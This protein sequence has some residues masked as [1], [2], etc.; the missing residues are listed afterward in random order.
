VGVGVGVG[1][2]VGVG[3][4]VGVGVGKWSWSSSS[5]CPP[6]LPLLLL[7]LPLLLVVIG[8]G[9][10]DAI[11]R[12]IGAGVGDA[13]DRG[14]GVGVGDGLAEALNVVV[15]FGF[16]PVPR[17]HASAGVQMLVGEMLLPSALQEL[18][19]AW[20]MARRRSFKLVCREVV[21]CVLFVAR[22]D[23]AEQ[24]A[25]ERF[26]EMSWTRPSTL[27]N[28]MMP[29]EGAVTLLNVAT[30]GVESVELP[31]SIVIT[32]GGRM[33][34]AATSARSNLRVPFTMASAVSM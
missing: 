31:T 32:A 4:G 34:E 2:G 8:I 25:V 11:G 29:V 9:V 22:A 6:P 3:I 12:G 28:G 24:E 26:P 5:S 21:P 18:L 10:G 14:I 23:T 15:N 27:V 30:T 20:T 17:T 16:V 1:A 13:D 19:A 33:E 7:P